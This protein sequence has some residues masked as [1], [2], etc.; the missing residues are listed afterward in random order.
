MTHS[1]A[2]SYAYCTKA[3]KKSGS[4]FVMSF[5]LLPRPKKEAMYALYAFLR[6]TDD[7]GDQPG[8]TADK[9]LALQ[10]WRNELNGALAGEAPTDLRLPA[11]VDTVRRYEIPLEYLTAVIDGVESDLT[12][13]PFPTF[14]ESQHYCYQVAAAVGL[15][16]LHVWGFQGAAALEPALA[17]GYAFQWT[18]ILRDLHEDA[19]VGR[20]YLPQDE[21]ARFDVSIEDLVAK[22][23]DE[24]FQSLM[25]FQIERAERFYEQAEPL[26]ALLHADGRK[27]F[28]AM[29]RTYRGL[30]IRISQDP[31]A[32]LRER[33]SVGAWEKMRIVASLM[34]AQMFHFVPSTTIGRR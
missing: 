3:A 28:P 26:Q 8:D 32:V 4:N 16:C 11:L 14:A 30:L 1:L 15:A 13:Q 5:M 2:E 17:C 18:N 25:R 9:R 23:G 6:Q 33:I 22:R 10:R 34:F 7:L 20:I 27:I 31:T 12:P 21:L 24:G 29:L 19:M